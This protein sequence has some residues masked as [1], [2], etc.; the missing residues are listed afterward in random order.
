MDSESAPYSLTTCLL[1]DKE[2]QQALGD[3]LLDSVRC[4]ESY[5]LATIGPT[6][7]ARNCRF[8][9]LSSFFCVKVKA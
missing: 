1:F 7:V 9:N 3:L 5:V 4:F 2:C 8:L 6:P